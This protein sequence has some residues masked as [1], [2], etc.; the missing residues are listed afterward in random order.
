MVVQL[1]QDLKDVQ[2]VNEQLDHMYVVQTRKGH[3]FVLPVGS[4]LAVGAPLQVRT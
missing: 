2:L 4:R 1:L 3:S